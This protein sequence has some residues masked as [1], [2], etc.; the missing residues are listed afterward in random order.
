LKLLPASSPKGSYSS[1]GAVDI[2]NNLSCKSKSFKISVTNISQLNQV[3]GIYIFLAKH[4]H[5]HRSLHTIQPQQLLR[6]L[7]AFAGTVITKV[8]HQP[9]R[10]F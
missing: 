2:R 8:Q 3:P 1:K 5:R 9:S 4:I 6:F 7:E 10:S